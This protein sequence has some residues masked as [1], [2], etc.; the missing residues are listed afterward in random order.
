MDD[1]TAAQ[2]PCAYRD[3]SEYRPGVLQA[4]ADVDGQLESGNM[5]G[6]SL[7]PGR[8]RWDVLTRVGPIQRGN[9]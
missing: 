2:P 4:F 5:D 6:R 3:A 1:C 8:R 9:C 7:V